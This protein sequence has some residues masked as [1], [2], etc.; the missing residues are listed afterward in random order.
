MKQ[1]ILASCFGALIGLT[2]SAQA[3]TSFVLDDVNV[4]DGTGKAPVAHSRV[5][6]S[7]GLIKAVGKREAVKIPEGAEVINLSGATLLPGLIS[8]HS[9]IGQYD[10]T[11]TQPPYNEESITRQLKQYNA[12]GVTTIGALGSNTSLFYGIQQKVRSGALIGPDLFGADRG[13]GVP[14]GAPPSSVLAGEI[15]RPSTPEEAREA[16]RASA[17][18]GA[19]LIKLWLDDFL[20][21]KLVKMKPEIYTAVIDEAHRNHLR[22]VGH[23]Y[24]QAD[25]KALMQA[26]VDILGHGVRD[27]VVDDE[28]IQLMRKHGTWYIPTLGVD[29]A[30]FRYAEHPELFQQTE[31]RK[32]LNAKLLAQLSSPEWAQSQLK[33]PNSPFWHS[34]LKNNLQNTKKLVDAGLS[35][36]FGTDSGAMPLRIPGYAEH[37]EL[38]LLVSAGLSPTQA[39]TIATSRAANLLKLSDRGEIRDGKRADLIAVAGDPTVDI[40][41]MDKILRVYQAGKAAELSPEPF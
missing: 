12:Y 39:L 20:G 2:S 4:F 18:R 7:D 23:I 26:G 25:A 40:R 24:Y 5:V 10:A 35:V 38:E 27:S 16:V 13:I 11:T 19:D 14:T 22:V 1:T 21:A 28:F 29:E 33:N 8:D 32:A 36:G 30:F 31:L 3:Q 37:R 41:A 6:V 9:H 15:D 34:G 17:K